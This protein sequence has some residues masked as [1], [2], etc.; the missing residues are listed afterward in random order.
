MCLRLSGLNPAALHWQKWYTVFITMFS[1]VYT[2]V[3]LLPNNEP[4]ICTEGAGPL[5]KVRHV[6]MAFSTVAQNGQF[7]LAQG[8]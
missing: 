6:A 7:L 3:C 8:I 1:Q 4:I 2:V 5:H